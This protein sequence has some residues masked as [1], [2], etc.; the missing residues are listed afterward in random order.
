MDIYNLEEILKESQ[1]EKVT[2]GLEGMVTAQFDIQN[3]KIISNKD[4][5]IFFDNSLMG[6]KS[7]VLSINKHQIM[8][9]TK[10]KKIIQLNGTICFLHL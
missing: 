10:K 8:K 3:V 7:Q 5:I 9:M 1:N 6:E 4:F 2:V